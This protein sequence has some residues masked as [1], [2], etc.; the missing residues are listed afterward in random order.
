ML[1][2]VKPKWLMICCAI[3]VGDT[4]RY[5]ALEHPAEARA[6]DRQFA[7]RGRGM[8]EEPFHARPDLPAREGPRMLSSSGVTALNKPAA[9]ASTESPE[10]STTAEARA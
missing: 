7:G 9:A 2:R 1:R 3:A 4:L 5:S 10:V 8:E 6:C